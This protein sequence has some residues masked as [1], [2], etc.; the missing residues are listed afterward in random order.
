MMLTVQSVQANVVG[1]YRPY[2][3]VAGSYRPYDDMEGMTWQ[4]LIGRHGR[5]IS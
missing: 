5:M 4:S 3:D 2:D 1:P